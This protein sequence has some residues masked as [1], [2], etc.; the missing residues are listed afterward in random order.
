[1]PI[2]YNYG[3]KKKSGK[4]GLTVLLYG[5]CKVHSPNFYGQ[6]LQLAIYVP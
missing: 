1:M 6:I 2:W 3:T 4:A 5:L